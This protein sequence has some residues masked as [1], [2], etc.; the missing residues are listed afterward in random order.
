MILKPF[1]IFGS[2][3]A[4]FSRNPVLNRSYHALGRHHNVAIVPAR[5]RK[6]RDKPSAENA[7]R[8]IEMW[9]LAPLRHRQFFSLAEA[10]VA[11]AQPLLLDASP[12]ERRAAVPAMRVEGAN[13]CG[14]SVIVGSKTL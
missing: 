10:N 7:V 1:L 4:R 5:V 12:F 9:V 3:R 2:S 6:P 13:P 14:T 11:A 8:L